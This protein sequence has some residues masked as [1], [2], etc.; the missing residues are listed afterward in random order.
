MKNYIIT[1]TFLLNIFNPL[2][3]QESKKYLDY[4]AIKKMAGCYNIEFNFAET[5]NY[6]DDSS[7]VKS[8]NKIA[9]AT[10]LVKVIKDTPSEIS[11]QHILVMGSGKNQFIIKHWRQDWLY[12]NR[13]FYMYEFDN[14]WI[15]KNYEP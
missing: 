7:Y 5:F 13:D 2:Y 11:L 8:P 1:M 12:E 10:E 14:K 3:S 4:Q 15:Y 9:Y 6:S